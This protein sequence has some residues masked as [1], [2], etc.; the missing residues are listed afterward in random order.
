MKRTILIAFFIYCFCTARVFG[1]DPNFSNFNNNKIYYNPGY[2]GMDYGLRLNSAYRRQ[3]PNIPGKFQTFY[4]CFDQ[5]IRVSRGTGG[6]GFIALSNTEGEGALQNISI[7]IPVSARIHLSENS[8]I[9]LGAM[10]SFSFNS[11]NWDRFVFSGQLDPFY[12]NINPSTFV[13]PDA[14]VSKKSYADIFNVGLVFRHENASPQANSSKFYRKFEAGISGFHLSEPNQSFTNSNA[15]LSAKYVF[16]ANYT[17]SVFLNYDG[18]MLIQPSFLTEMQWKMH[19]YMAGVNTSFTDYNIDFGVWWRNRNIDLRNTDAII[20]MFGYRFIVDKNNNSILNTSLSYDI[21][22]SKLNGATM[23]SPEIS[24]S[25]TINN[26]SFFHDKPDACDNNSR[27]I[28][29]RRK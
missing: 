28:N 19:S 29:R 3:W 6:F 7:G 1:Q 11:I 20:V 18:Y 27:W 24:V 17:T 12:G 10:P 13:P 2:V 4:A 5:S 26:G 9:Q 16:F 15:P 22:V 14:G 23:G 25:L 21:T 8:I